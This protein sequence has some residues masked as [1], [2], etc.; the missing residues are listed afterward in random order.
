M[1]ISRATQ[2]IAR[3][4]AVQQTRKFVSRSA[5]R[6]GHNLEDYYLWPEFNAAMVNPMFEYA[7]NT[8]LFLVGILSVWPLMHSNYY[9]SGRFLPKDP[10]CL[11]LDDSW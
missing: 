4:F 9:F 2:V 8:T 7:F 1:I 3:K 11:L 5:P 6:F 10:E